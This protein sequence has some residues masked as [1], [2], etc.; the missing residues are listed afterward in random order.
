M[1]PLKE[2]IQK[3]ESAKSLYIQKRSRLDQWIGDFQKLEND[4][5]E[6]N[7][8][9]EQVYVDSAIGEEYAEDIKEKLENRRDG[10]RLSTKSVGKLLRKLNLEKP[11]EENRVE[12]LL[13]DEQEKL[14][15]H[16][17]INESPEGRVELSNVE[18]N[19]E[20]DGNPEAEKKLSEHFLDENEV[21]VNKEETAIESQA[22][23]YS[24]DRLAVLQEITNQYEEAEQQ[25]SQLIEG[26]ESRFLKFIEKS[27]APIMDGLVSGHYYGKELLEEIKASG[28]SPIQSV[29]DWLNV[30]SK[31]LKPIDK[32]FDENGIKRYFPKIGDRFDEHSHEPIGV[33][34]DPNF[35]DEQIKEVTRI[36]LIYKKNIDSQPQF[37]IRPAQVIVVKNN[38]QMNQQEETAREN[39]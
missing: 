8:I 10:V 29:E 13:H 2:Q 1:T 27:V 3:Y 5:N 12:V 9:F 16:L 26:A 32:L 20:E 35:E 22:D 33:V 14:L 17:L 39:G 37:L 31:L 15:S 11:I 23:S 24:V 30:Y 36:G 21:E 25:L 6:L 28:Y 38:R 34:E 19:V 7:L 18:G 4:I